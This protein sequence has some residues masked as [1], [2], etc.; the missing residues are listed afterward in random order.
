[1][2]EFGFGSFGLH[3]FLRSSSARLL[4]V[5]G[6]GCC[7][8]Y[9]AFSVSHIGK[10]VIPAHSSVRRLPEFSSVATP[11]PQLEAASNDNGYGKAEVPQVVDCYHFPFCTRM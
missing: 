9:S 8:A 2:L 3:C 6:P 1:M 5:L 4:V 7:W 11:A 10:H